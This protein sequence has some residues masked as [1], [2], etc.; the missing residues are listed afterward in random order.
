MGETTH[1]SEDL[2]LSLGYV[3]RDP[4]LL[5]QALSHRSWCGEVEGGRPSNERLEFLGDA[6]LGLVVAEHCYLTYQDLPEGSLAQ[7]RAQV[8]NT[9]VL[10][11]VAG[12]LDLGSSVLLGRGEDQSGGRSKPSILAD[13][14]E[15]VIG[16]VYLDGGFEPATDLILRL[17]GSR[18]D[19]AAAGPGAFD[20]KTR[21][22]EVVLREVGELPRYRVEGEG[23]D[24]ARRYTASVTVL[25]EELGVGSGRSKKDAEQEAA[26]SAW[27]VFAGRTRH[28]GDSE[29][30]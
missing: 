27:Q 9:T 29:G 22:Q 7:V 21:F 20:H 26:R 12:E 2:T 18:I 5:L 6:V 17:L 3:F 30:A 15:S 28:G 16:A 14:L 25:G 8:V 19:A 4:G 13:S 10:A 24:H 1:L 23:P 11:E